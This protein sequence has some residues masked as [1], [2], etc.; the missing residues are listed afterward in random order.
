MRALA[1]CMILHLKSLSSVPCGNADNASGNWEFTQRQSWF[2]VRNNQVEVAV[3]CTLVSL[4]LSEG[5]K[6]TEGQ[7]K[8]PDSTFSFSLLNSYKNP[9]KFLQQP[10]VFQDHFDPCISIQLQPTHSCLSV[11]SEG[12]LL[13]SPAVSQH[14]WKSISPLFATKLAKW[15]S[16]KGKNVSL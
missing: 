1:V 11:Y 12:G 4:G 16:A 6:E 14:S 7:A 2:S 8:H 3:T 15:T 9:T 13:V 10:P 5:C